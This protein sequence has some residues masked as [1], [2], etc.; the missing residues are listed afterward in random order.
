MSAG[1]MTI[2]SPVFVY[3]FGSPQLLDKYS[4]A[5][6]IGLRSSGLLLAVLLPLLLT[7]V[8]FLGPSAMLLL[9]VRLDTAANLRPH[10]LSSLQ[11][12]FRVFC[13][14]MFWRQSAQ[15]WIWW[16]N[17]VV[18]PFSEE[19]TFR[20]CMVP[21]LLGEDTRHEASSGVMS[22]I[23][24]ALLPVLGHHNQSTLL[25]SGSLPSHGGEDQ[26]R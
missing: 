6:I 1:F 5:E 13:V 15:D 17:H 4:L 20:A 3:Q 24:R 26:E 22:D 12:R 10:C 23:C 21:V 18:A 9:D 8:L 14:P 11:E 2:I 7:L 16:R 19:F 25:R